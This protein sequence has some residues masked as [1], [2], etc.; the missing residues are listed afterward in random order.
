MQTTSF[1]KIE[2]RAFSSVMVTGNMR[3]AV[4]GFHAGLF[5][6]DAS[7]L[8]Q[9]RVLLIICVAFAI[10]AGIGA[11]MTVGVGARALLLPIMLLIAVLVR[12]L[13]TAELGPIHLG[14]T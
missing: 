11:V 12:C 6:N 14:R 13:W 4:E 7:E 8:R 2:G 5:E 10:G 1:A 9:A 3:R